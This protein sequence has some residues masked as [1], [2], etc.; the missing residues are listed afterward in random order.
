[1]LTPASA[2]LQSGRLGCPS[3][4]GTMHE[5]QIPTP[6]TIDCFWPHRWRERA[7]A[8]KDATGSCDP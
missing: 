3:L 4:I 5:H 6:S 2:L 8:L 1:M 7:A